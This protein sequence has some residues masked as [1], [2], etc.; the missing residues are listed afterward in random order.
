MTVSITRGYTR[1][2]TRTDAN[3]LEIS[4]FASV[5]DGNRDF[6]MTRVSLIQVWLQ[7]RAAICL[8]LCFFAG[9]RQ[10]G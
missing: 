2:A 1:P 6:P 9:R 3:K 8:S 10:T 4:R 5:I 7:P